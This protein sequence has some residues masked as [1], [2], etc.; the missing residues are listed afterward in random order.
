MSSTI[1]FTSTL[2]S[3]LMDWL[4][5]Y[6]KE[7][8]TTQRAVLEEALTRLKRE[9]KRARMEESF[10]RASLDPE[11]HQMAE[12]GLADYCEQLKRLAV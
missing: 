12:E 11:M 5:G 7:K 1:T 8:K 4:R 10:K 3:R 6:A 9:E 2:S